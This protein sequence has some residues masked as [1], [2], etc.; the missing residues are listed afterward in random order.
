MSE[1]IVTD[2]SFPTF[3]D[4]IASLEEQEVSLSHSVTQQFTFSI[5]QKP[6]HAF[7]KIYEYT[8]VYL[9]IP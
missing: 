8:K 6:Y 5:L 3:L 9:S 2:G 4:A 1:K 7:M